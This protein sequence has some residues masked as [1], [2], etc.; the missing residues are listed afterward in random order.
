MSV[1]RYPERLR[2]YT[3]HK[4][5]GYTIIRDPDDHHESIEYS[6]NMTQIRKFYS[7]LILRKDPEPRNVESV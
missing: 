3:I 6:T 5:K 4:D 1:E 2:Y 7:P